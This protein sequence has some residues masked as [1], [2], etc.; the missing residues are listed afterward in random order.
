[1][2]QEQLKK[3]WEYILSGAKAYENPRDYAKEYTS[4]LHKKQCS[5]REFIEVIDLKEIYNEQ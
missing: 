4:L 1:M 2:D 3:V 5:T